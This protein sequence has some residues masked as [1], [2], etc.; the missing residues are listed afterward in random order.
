MAR[1]VVLAVLVR[2]HAEIRGYL[3]DNLP[4][5]G[6]FISTLRFYVAKYMWLAT[7]IP[8]YAVTLAL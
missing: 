4:G 8:T 2:K 1:G 6:R 5:C 3:G 7:V